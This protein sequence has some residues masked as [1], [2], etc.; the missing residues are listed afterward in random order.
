MDSPTENLVSPLDYLRPV[1]RFRWAALAMVIVAAAATY[2][3]FDRQSRTYEASTQLY[4]GQSDINALLGAQTSNAGGDARSLANQARLV[5]TPSVATVVIRR[6]GLDTTPDALLEDISVRPDTQ[7]DF[8]TI[9]AD[10]GA[11]RLAAHLVNGFAQ[12]YLQVRA[13][14][15]KKLV[16]VQLK[17][18]R[19]QLTRTPK[20][21]SNI[22]TRSAL[23]ERIQEL[24]SAAL[25]PQAV[26]EQLSTAQP[27]HFAIAPK[28]GRNAVFAAALAFLFALVLAYVFDRSDRR[29]RSIE[30]MEAMFDTAILAGIPR[31]SNPVPGHGSRDDMTLDLREPY[32]TLRVN[33]ELIRNKR[34]GGNSMLVTSALPSEGKSTVV[35]NLALAY[36]DAGMRVA[37]VDADLRRS[38]MATLFDLARAP[39]TAEVLRGTVALKDA[40]QPLA[41][42]QQ[43]R[44]APQGRATKPPTRQASGQLDVLTAGEGGENP[45]LLFY[46]VAVRQLVSELE[47]SYD[48]VLI[49][50]PPVLVVSDALAVAP[51]IDGVVLVGRIGV[52]TGASAQ[53]LLRTFEGVPQTQVM[54]A[55]AN[56]ISLDETYTY[57]Y[58]GPADRP[59]DDGP[60]SSNGIQ[61]PEATDPALQ[62]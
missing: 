21:D 41:S 60:P 50:T 3:Y 48:I 26:G 36:R 1:W 25:N 7:A 38:S 51:E 28:P 56:A 4:V 44:L 35:R 37:V 55:V 54:G 23:R 61:R 18:S 53:R 34:G 15:E 13:E 12:G 6:L 59:P 10:A 42:D 57:A 31:V 24:E 9:V 16:D 11:A 19:L 14:Q 22:A 33:L 43:V 58:Y 8:L 29:L 5:T 17:V 40:I 45:G 49:D 52:T 20:N 27:P 39:G 47:E 2:A 46:P 30:D 62:Q 32:H